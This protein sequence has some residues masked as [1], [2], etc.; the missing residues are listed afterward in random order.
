ML[1]G[2]QLQ[3]GPVDPDDVA[4]LRVALARIARVLD[5]RSRGEAL[6]GTQVSVL[7]TADRLG[8]V[9]LGELAEIEGVNPTMLSR[10]VAKLEDDGLLARHP[11][12]ADGRA[13]RVEVTAEGRAL[14]E[15]QRAERS[16]LLAARLD[17]L[18]APEAGALLA[19]LPV[20]ERLA[21]DL[22]ENA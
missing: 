3:G 14:H 12:P 11:D 20:L 4:R 19:A 13:A 17:A 18:P 5:R 15:R 22:V 10:I 6:T 1:V 9:R 2:K 7:A 16:R 21:H 8:P